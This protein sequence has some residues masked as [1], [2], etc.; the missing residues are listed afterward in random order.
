[1]ASRLG[2][3]ADKCKMLDELMDEWLAYR[4][5]YPEAFD[6]SDED[7]EIENP[8]QAPKSFGDGEHGGP[9]LKIHGEE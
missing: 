6:E 8:L 7:C 1:M 5:K 3:I 9:P 4:K 2:T